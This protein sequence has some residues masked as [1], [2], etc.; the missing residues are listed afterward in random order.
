MADGAPRIGP[1]PPDRPGEL[2]LD[3]PDWAS[4]DSERDRLPRPKPAERSSR[5]K[6]S[7]RA[8]TSAILSLALVLS[9]IV[10]AQS[11]I[12]SA[13]P[14]PARWLPESRSAEATS[15]TKSKCTHPGCKDEG[16]ETP[17]PSACCFTWAPAVS[18]VSLAPPTL[19]PDPRLSD[20]SLGTVA[21][22]LS[23]AA[24]SAHPA[25]SFPPGEVPAPHLLLCTSLLGRAPPL[26]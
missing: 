2:P 9:T 14:Q 5:M 22:T 12:R 15:T 19:V 16:S 13:A 10:C 1:T 20:E 3:H 21:I 24:Q 11:S 18:P 23:D 26:A 7:H 6:R 8:S 17:P 25:W 4:N